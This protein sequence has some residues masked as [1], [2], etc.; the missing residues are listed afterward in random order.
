MPIR[1]ATLT[2]RISRN[3]QALHR[4]MMRHSNAPGADQQP[5]KAELVLIE[6]RRLLK[7]QR[8]E[9]HA[10]ALQP[11]PKAIDRLV[12]T[13][14]AEP[15]ETPKAAKEAHDVKKPKAR[16]SRAQKHAEKAAAL[17]AA[18]RSP[19]KPPK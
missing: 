18:R 12:R 5:S 2:K 13:H 6:E 14:H 10:E 11:R 9:R 1:T 15:K 4:A 16:M 7:E 3:G 17:E 8:E 19:K